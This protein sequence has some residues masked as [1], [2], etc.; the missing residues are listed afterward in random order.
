M[1]EGSY[2]ERVE[3]AGGQ[4]EYSEKVLLYGK[5]LMLVRLKLKNE[6]RPYFEV[7]WGN[8]RIYRANRETEMQEY[9]DAQGVYFILT[10]YNINPADLKER[11][12]IEILKSFKTAQIKAW[13][14]SISD[15]RESIGA[16]KDMFSEEEWS[17]I[18]NLL[19]ISE[20]ESIKEIVDDGN[21]LPLA[22][23]PARL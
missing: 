17:N 13:E 6:S 1:K 8:E 12:V 19:S 9:T 21:W 4:I 20:D 15:A 22:D 23:Y 10:A 3:A 5:D 16:R 2:T 14:K 7:A 18:E 11:E